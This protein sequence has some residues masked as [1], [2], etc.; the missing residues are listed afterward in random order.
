MA[1]S[2]LSQASHEGLPGLEEVKVDGV[3]CVDGL[4]TAVRSALSPDGV[5]AYVAGLL[6]A[7]IA[8]FELP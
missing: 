6:E 5:D 7:K 2:C 8:I 1:A 4:E 3:D